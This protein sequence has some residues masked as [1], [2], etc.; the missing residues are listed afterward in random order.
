MTKILYILVLTILFG[1][2]S[3]FQKVY[4]NEDKSAKLALGEKLY[5][6]GSITKAQR[7][8]TQIVPNYRG[9][10][11]AEKLMYLYANTYYLQK[12][13]ETAAYQLERFVKAY[14]T[15]EKLEEMAFK[16]AKSHSK[17]S[18]RSS[19]DQNYTERAIVKLENFMKTYPKSEYFKDANTLAIKLDEKLQKK[20]Y[21]IAKGYHHRI[22]TGTQ[23]KD[24]YYAAIAAL[25]NFLLN[26]PGTIYKEKAMYYI[27]DTAFLLAKNSTK[28]R[29]EERLNQAVEYYIKFSKKYPTSK[30]KE[31]AAE[32]FEIITNE[33][34]EFKNK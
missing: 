6:K 27:Y 3:E 18:P 31:V 29:K 22:S 9:K 15:S 34:K 28:R 24:D 14:P 32:S 21:D 8:F 11:G 20:A 17:L 19:L 16:S 5:N 2:C 25:E 30:F 26:Y 23:F 4:K 10:P 7:L 13:W 1:S 33:L 12:S